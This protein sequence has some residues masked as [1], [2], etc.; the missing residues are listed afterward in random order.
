[1]NHSPI[2]LLPALQ[3]RCWQ[4]LQAGMRLRVVSG[5]LW[6]TQSGDAQDH[7]LHA[8]DALHLS[9]QRVVIEAQCDTRYVFEAAQPPEAHPLWRLFWRWL[10]KKPHRLAQAGL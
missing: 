4:P 2:E 5:R 8:G 3:L 1:M 6:L 9:D 10:R 7:F